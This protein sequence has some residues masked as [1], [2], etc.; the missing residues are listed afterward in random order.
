MRITYFLDVLE[1][2]SPNPSPGPWVSPSYKP[3]LSLH[4]VE[5]DGLLCLWLHT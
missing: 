1:M 3:V 5:P 4:E 2:F